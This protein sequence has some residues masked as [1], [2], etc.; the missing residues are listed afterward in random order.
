MF[1]R[2]CLIVVLGFLGLCV[3]GCGVG[4]FVGVPWLRGNVRD[5]IRDGIATEVAVQIPAVPG[6]GVEPGTYQFTEAELL[7]NLRA[8]SEDANIDDLLLDISPSG[9]KLGLTVP[10]NQD[11]TYEGVPTVEN[12]R[13]VIEDMSVDNDGLEFLLPADDLAGAIEDGVNDYLAANGQ[14]LTA[15]NLGDGTLS[16]TTEDAP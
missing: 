13:L 9:L 12:G 1:R 10:G 8:T 11:G 2:G 14:H 5:S 15:V 7:R 6:A 4:Y 16:L 3:V